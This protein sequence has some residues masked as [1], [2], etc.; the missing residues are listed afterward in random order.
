MDLEG[1][2]VGERGV[3]ARQRTA[4]S[5]ADVL[6]DGDLPFDP[7]L[8]HPEEQ[9]AATRN[10]RRSAVQRGYKKTSPRGFAEEVGATATG[11]SLPLIFPRARARQDLAPF[12]TA[13]GRAAVARASTGLLPPPF[14]MSYQ[15]HRF[16]RVN[17]LCRPAGFQMGAS[18]FSCL[19]YTAAKPAPPP[20]PYHLFFHP[21]EKQ[22]HS[23]LF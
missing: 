2:W 4:P 15:K 17:I 19:S 18:F 21:S 16:M 8:I 23:G 14:W 12:L 10:G 5:A 1:D 20:A 11:A 7:G 22:P 13:F 9:G 6:P 3:L